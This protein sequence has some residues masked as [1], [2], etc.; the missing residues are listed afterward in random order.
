MADEV[1]N[2]SS[3][4]VAQEKVYLPLKTMFVSE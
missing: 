2:V 1:E 4:R 3:Q